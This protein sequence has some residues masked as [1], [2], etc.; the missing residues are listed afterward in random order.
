MAST[1]PAS[2]ALGTFS[3]AGCPPFSGLVLG[4]EHVVA[5]ESLRPLCGAQGFDLPDA[6]STL[7]LIEHWRASLPA[8]QA[9]ADA[10]SAPATSL[11][12]AVAE[13]LASMSSLQ[14]HPPVASR[15]IFMS[16]ANYFKHVVDI[17]VD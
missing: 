4:S 14:V 5:I 15:Q 1:S 8:L 3:L 10:L 13:R 7:S 17:I 6:S 2:F 11:A 12:R 16:G 9:V